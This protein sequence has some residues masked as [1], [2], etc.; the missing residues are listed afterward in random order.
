MIARAASLI[1]LVYALG[2]ILF[3]VT[4]GKPAPADAEPT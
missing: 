1:A 3:A 2:F 4:F